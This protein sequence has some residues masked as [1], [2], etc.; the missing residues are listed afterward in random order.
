MSYN[1]ESCC[2][3]GRLDELL[4][5]A[6]TLGAA[7]CCLQSTCSEATGSWIT[8]KWKCFS[9]P[10]QS[11]KGNDGCIIAV[12]TH[13]IPLAAVS[14][15]HQWEPGRAHGLRLRQQTTP[16]VDIY[17]LNSY[18]PTDDIAGDVDIKRANE[19]KKR[20][21]WHSI[22]VALRSLPART[23]LVWTMDGNARTKSTPPPWIGSAGAT[24][25]HE[26]QAWNGNGRLLLEL[27]Q[28]HHLVAVNTVGS[29]AEPS[30]TWL[31]PQGGKIR[32]DYVVTRTRDSHRAAAKVDYDA[33]VSLSGYRDHRPLVATISTEATFLHQPKRQQRFAWDRQRLGQ[34]LQEITALEEGSAP[35]LGEDGQAGMRVID[36]VR[37]QLQTLDAAS[38]GN[39]ESLLAQIEDIVVR[40]AATEFQQ[41]GFR[42]RRRRPALQWGTVQLINQKHDLL[43]WLG[44]AWY[45]L[46]VDHQ[47]YWTEEF[48]QLQRAARRAVRRDKRWEVMKLLDDAQGAA[49]A[50][51]TRELFKIIHRLAPQPRGGCDALRSPDGVCWDEEA[52]LDERGRALRHI[53]DGH[54]QDIDIQPEREFEATPEDWRAVGQSL[55]ASAIVAAVHRLPDGKAGPETRIPPA[56]Q[57]ASGSIA[58]VWKLVASTAAPWL[59]DAW[60][61]GCA[62]GRLS[63]TLKN[64]E[65]CFLPKPGKDASDAVKGW[66]TI[67]LLH[68]LGKAMVGAVLEPVKRT[69]TGSLRSNQYGALP[70]RGTRD[71]IAVVE[72]TLARFRQGRG[73]QGQNRRRPRLMAAILFDLEK[74]FDKVPRQKAWRIIQEK[75]RG[76]G[77]EAFFQ[78]L[79]D[80]TC[81]LLK[82]ARGDIRRRL[83]IRQGVRQGSI[84]G[85]LVFICLYDVILMNLGKRRPDGKK[86]AA[87]MKRP[88]FARQRDDELEVGDIAFVDDL[89][90]MI[91]FEE[92]EELEEWIQAV[93]EV[94]Q[95]LDMQANLDKLELLVHAS[96]AG[97]K[98]TNA[99]VRRGKFVLHLRDGT[100]VRAQ[101]H[102]RYLGVH[103]VAD[104]KHSV[105]IGKRLQKAEWA[106][107]LLSQRIWKNAGWGLSLVTRVWTVLVRSI[108][109]YG[110]EVH[111]L[112]R[113]D[114]HRLE[115]FQNKCLRH[116]GKSP[117]HLT[118][119][120][121]CDLRRRLRIPTLASVIRRQRIGWWRKIVQPGYWRPLRPGYA[122]RPMRGSLRQD[123]SELTRTSLLGVL[124]FE[125]DGADDMT[126]E[127]QALLLDD[128]GHLRAALQKAADD[129]NDRM[130]QPCVRA[131]AALRQPVD[132]PPT[133]SRQWLEW[134]ANLSSEAMDAVLTYETEDGTEQEPLVQCSCGRLCRGQMGLAVHRS[135]WCPVTTEARA[136]AKE[137]QQAA[138][139]AAQTSRWT[140][141]RCLQTF[142][143]RDGWVKHVKRCECTPR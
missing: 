98:H 91:E 25:P 47:I 24:W 37:N 5:T 2:H 95:M 123:P 76:Y 116:I 55:H 72:D 50:M 126:T 45:D 38:S 87:R 104:G 142:A 57:P 107:R 140:C 64:G 121:T 6:E 110:L 136:S 58:E 44:W 29:A 42:R 74:A 67:N 106:H 32:L 111:A 79:H 103:I 23:A 49:Q 119:E 127:R 65:I 43:R 129:G 133:V 75:A 97:S 20:K 46:P 131:L 52:E 10:K 89:I 96:G 101:R 99:Q 84:E 108:L 51:D 128:L 62:S 4:H 86:L 8:R 134:L 132:A 60:Q 11:A 31:S 39:C 130:H 71:A 80:G 77:I 3:A 48:V 28:E 73:L 18:A 109:L 19:E 35:G 70:Q 22:D 16:E 90:S 69:L 7:V 118:R 33:P 102:A 114:L 81:Y 30:W 100:K 122:P 120:S 82:N 41:D 14:V 63:Q 112:C 13:D 137:S 54:D 61:A 12:N 9:S 85:P 36:E 113:R 141:E 15:Y 34:A 93:A 59:Q 53:F 21:H 78:E 139:A 66:R 56:G 68:H 138:R 94:F 88:L 92:K 26:T 17:I 27:L 40:T 1:C 125:G 115:K 124:S 105:E 143:R 135:R 83:W 117:V